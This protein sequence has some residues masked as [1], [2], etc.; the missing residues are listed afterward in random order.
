MPYGL[1]NLPVEAAPST[2]PMPLP[3][4]VVISPVATTIFRIT[5]LALASA[6]YKLPSP[7]PQT[8]EGKLID[9]EVLMLPAI[10]LVSAGGLIV[11]VATGL[12]PC[13]VVTV[14]VRKPAE[15]VASMANVA[16]IDVALTTLILLTLTPF[17]AQIMS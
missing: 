9:A 13:V 12:V 3:A 11:N 6:T 8:F 4:S 1:L 14:M 15:A 2:K 17:P 16:V 5:E 7:S 10:V